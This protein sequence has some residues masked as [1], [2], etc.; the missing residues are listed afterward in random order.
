MSIELELDGVTVHVDYHDSGDEET[1]S[2]ERV[3]I[4]NAD[5]AEGNYDS[6][7]SKVLLARFRGDADWLKEMARKQWDAAREPDPDRY[8]FTETGRR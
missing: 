4:D 1:F 2:I 7:D 8:T 6:A 5:D 3:V